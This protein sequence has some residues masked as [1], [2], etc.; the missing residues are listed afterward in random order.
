MHHFTLRYQLGEPCVDRQSHDV[1]RFWDLSNVTG[2][3]QEGGCSLVDENITIS[4]I[5]HQA[6]VLS[7]MADFDT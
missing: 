1:F 2:E 6:G 7:V 5:D 3:A 4:L